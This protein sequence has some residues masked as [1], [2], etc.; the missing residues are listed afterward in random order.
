MLYPIVAVVMVVLLAGPERWLSGRWWS[1][2]WWTAPLPAI[3]DW[4]SEVLGRSRHRPRRQVLVTVVV[5][6]ALGAALA[7]W[8]RHP[9]AWRVVVP[10][11]VQGAVV[12]L[13]WVRGRTHLG[14]LDPE[15]EVAFERDE[16]ARRAR[17]GALVGVADPGPAD[18]PGRPER[19]PRPPQAVTKSNSSS[20]A[21]TRDGSRS[22]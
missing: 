17:L 2:L 15:W 7:E 14:S 21:P 9:G 12:G 19:S 3:A 8:V 18:D 16:A 4:A 11:A 22:L 5:A 6:P 1:V 20:T 13:V 10:F